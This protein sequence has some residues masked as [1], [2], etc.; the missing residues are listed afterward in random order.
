MGKEKLSTRT[1]KKLLRPIHTKINPDA[2]E[3]IDRQVKKKVFPSRNNAINIAV[4]EKFLTEKE[5]K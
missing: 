2:I 4:E 3:E 5:I 1:G